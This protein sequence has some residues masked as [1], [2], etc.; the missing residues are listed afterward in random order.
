MIARRKSRVSLVI[1]LIV[2]SCTL[3][4]GGGATYTLEQYDVTYEELFILER[5]TLSNDD[6][7][8]CLEVG[9]GWNGDTLEIEQTDNSVTLLLSLDNVSWIEVA[10]HTL[11]QDE[12]YSNISK[13]FRICNSL[14][15][16]FPF[17]VEEGETIYI[18]VTFR[19][20]KVSTVLEYNPDIQLYLTAILVSKDITRLWYFTIDW[21]IPG[22]FGA[23]F[24]SVFAVFLISRRNRMKLERLRSKSES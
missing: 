8:T 13:T 4:F 22:M 24:L 15:E 1:I 2:L 21:T 17:D 5:A 14:I 18:S 3:V 9:Y 11:N 10:K 6:W 23:L 19:Y 20:D 12:L 16:P 7:G